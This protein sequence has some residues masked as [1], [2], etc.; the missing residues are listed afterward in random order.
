[1]SYLMRPISNVLQIL[2]DLSQASVALQ[3]I[4]TLGLSLTSRA[5]T[6]A[7][8]TTHSSEFKQIDIH[9]A[10]HNYQK[11]GEET[12]FT[13]EPIDLTLNP[14]ELVFIVGG[15][16]SGKSTL[17]KLLTGLYSG[18]QEH[19]GHLKSCT[20]SQVRLLKID[21]PHQLANRCMYPTVE[22]FG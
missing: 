9:Q 1:M 15:N 18:Y 4:E 8:T 11:V 16:G 7:R 22:I 3:K 19:R 20:S 21:V 5:E 17:A 10:T 14:G 2:P 12:T 6:L 13:L